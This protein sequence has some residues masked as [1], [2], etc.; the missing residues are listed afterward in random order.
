MTINMS[1]E[2]SKP[3]NNENPPIMVSNLDTNML[4]PYGAPI[5]N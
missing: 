4:D 5:Q 3:S 1:S 2:K